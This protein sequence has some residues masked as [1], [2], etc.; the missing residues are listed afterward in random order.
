MMRSLSL[1]KFIKTGTWCLHCM[2]M[3]CALLLWNARTQRK[4]AWSSNL[5]ECPLLCIWV[6][7][8][9]QLW[10]AVYSV[11]CSTAL[12]PSLLFMASRGRGI[13][14]WYLDWVIAIFWSKPIS[15]NNSYLG[16][17]YIPDKSILLIGGKGWWPPNLYRMYYV[18]TIFKL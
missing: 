12:Q 2:L 13:F 17:H 6:H 4:F 7:K 18:R 1:D 9:K 10:V 11:I 15:M 16:F 8:A 3:W 14:H 5:L